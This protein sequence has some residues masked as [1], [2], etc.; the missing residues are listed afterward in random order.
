MQG[1][2]WVESLVSPQ[3]NHA[4]DSPIPDTWDRASQ[5][6]PIR[7]CLPLYFGSRYLHLHAFAAH[8]GSLRPTAAASWCCLLQLPAEFHLR[9]QLQVRQSCCPSCPSDAASR[10]SPVALHCLLPLRT[11][12]RLH[13]CHLCVQ[14]APAADRCRSSSVPGRQQRLTDTPIAPAAQWALPA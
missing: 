5:R 10:R 11:R 3:L 2:G 8:R 12:R 4:S 1:T 7:P 13:P 9:N 6:H 14:D